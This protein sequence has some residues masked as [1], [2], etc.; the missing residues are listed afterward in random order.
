[1][2]KLLKAKMTRISIV[3]GGIS[4]EAARRCCSVPEGRKVGK[5]ANEVMAQK[6]MSPA[7]DARENMLTEQ[8][9]YGGTSDSWSSTK[10]WTDKLGGRMAARR[11]QSDRCNDPCQRQATQVEGASEPHGKSLVSTKVARLTSS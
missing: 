7:K 10:G 3:S 5:R 8:F 9:L 2:V 6:I 11:N 1:M 4:M